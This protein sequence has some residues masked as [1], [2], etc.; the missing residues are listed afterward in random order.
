MSTLPTSVFRMCYTV[1]YTCYLQTTIQEKK[2]YE[3]FNF[4][5][6]LQS[7]HG[8]F[9]NYIAQIKGFAPVKNQKLFRALYK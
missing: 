6:Y 7:R 1:I 9:H 4:P 5:P 2:T 3:V 8:N